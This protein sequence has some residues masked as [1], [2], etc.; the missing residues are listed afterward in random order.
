MMRRVLTWL[1][2]RMQ[3]PRVIYD[4]EGKSPYL[5]R[6][7][8]IGSR[9][10]ADGSSPVDQFGDPKPDA[11]SSPGIHLY[12][13]RFHRSDADGALHSH[14]WSWAYALIL[15]GGYKEERRFRSRLRPGRPY[16]VYQLTRKPWSVVPIR[17]TD[18][19]RVDL[20]EHDSWSLFLAGPKVASWGFWDRNTGEFLPW[21]EFIA[22]I[23]GELS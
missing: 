16:F 9:R 13:H 12:L 4:R 21:R 2:D 19:H 6:W 18:F 15:A 7:A 23:R 20:L 14:P 11:I 5:S 10:M 17:E 3:P 8:L 22:K 1:T